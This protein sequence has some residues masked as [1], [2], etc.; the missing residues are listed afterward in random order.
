MG[1]LWWRPKD[2]PPGTKPLVTVVVGAARP[3]LRDS[4]LREV[5][6]AASGQ[7][8]PADLLLS[9]L[10]QECQ[11]YHCGTLEPAWTWLFLSLRRLPVERLRNKSFGAM[12][13]KPRT[14]VALAHRLDGRIVDRL[15]AARAVATDRELSLR[16]A[17]LA[18]RDFLDHGA[19]PET[20]VLC[21]AADAAT[22]ARLLGGGAP[23]PGQAFRRRLAD[24]QYYHALAVAALS[25]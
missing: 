13:I 22:A 5:D 7:S 1:E 16:L 12:S 8:V 3:G 10:L 19:T 2:R 15:E 17:A 18:L 23:W 4:I 24:H 9:L 21:Y 11:F 25:D 20:A 6:T 14:A